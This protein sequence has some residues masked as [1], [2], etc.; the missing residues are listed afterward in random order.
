MRRTD[1]RFMGVVALLI[2]IIYLVTMKKKTVVDLRPVA[3][4]RLNIVTNTKPTSC[5]AESEAQVIKLAEEYSVSVVIFVHSLSE[6]VISQTV[7]SVISHSDPRLLKEI[8]I[9]NHGE[10]EQSKFQ[11]IQAEFKDYDPLIKVMSSGSKTEARNKLHVGLVAEGDVVVFLDDNV[12]VS[13][14]FLVPLLEAID[15]KS[16]V[17]YILSYHV[18]VTHTLIS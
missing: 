3:K 16:Q 1:Y 15:R 4:D 5:P 10:L 17:C 9:A 8:I 12:V 7:Y 6:S 11:M 18:L 2:I 14:G 13:D